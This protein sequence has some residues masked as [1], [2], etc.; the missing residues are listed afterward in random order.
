MQNEVERKIRILALCT[1]IANA[2]DVANWLGIPFPANVFNFHPS[3][4]PV[5]LEIHIQGF[6][7]NNKSTRVMAMSRPA[8]NQLKKNLVI[9]TES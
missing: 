6:D 8:Y 7:H 2:K 5:P 9:N 3:V 4:R 1:P